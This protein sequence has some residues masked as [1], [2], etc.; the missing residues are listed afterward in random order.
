[1]AGGPVFLRHPVDSIRLLYRR[2]EYTQTHYSAAIIDVARFSDKKS[3][4]MCVI[5]SYICESTSKPAESNHIFPVNV[6]ALPDSG[7][8]LHIN[9]GKCRLTACAARSIT[10]WRVNLDMT[11]V[12][13]TSV[14]VIRQHCNLYHISTHSTG[15][16]RG[17]RFRLRS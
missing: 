16:R 12:S 10:H 9:G 17:A 3:A 13:I 4:Y 7:V 2:S 6:A 1:M 14:L 5:Y 15:C 11:E 8:L